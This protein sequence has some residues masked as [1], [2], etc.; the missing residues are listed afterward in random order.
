MIEGYISKTKKMSN[1]NPTKLKAPLRLIMN[2]LKVLVLKNGLSDSSVVP[3]FEEQI[4]SVYLLTKLLS[5]IMSVKNEHKSYL[6]KRAVLEEKKM[7]LN[8]LEEVLVDLKKE[9][10][11]VA[12]D[13][14]RDITNRSKRDKFLRKNLKV[15]E[16]G[17][18]V[19]DVLFEVEELSGGLLKP[20]SDASLLVEL[21]V[22]HYIVQGLMGLE[23][24]IERMYSSGVTEKHY[25]LLKRY[26][27]IYS[28]SLE[29]N[30]GL[31]KIEQLML[32]F[33]NP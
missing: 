6:K 31:R 14:K 9:R 15:K 17:K 23:S 22:L 28:I 3:M 8:S 13:Y 7:I 32:S 26:C 27:K 29:S 12:E 25:N 2:R 5:L 18:L 16:M 21:E 1:R 10:L 11:L 19:I 4:S 24:S 20:K 30:K 33:V